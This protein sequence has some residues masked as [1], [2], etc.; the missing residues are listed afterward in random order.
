MI[1]IFQLILTGAVLF[2]LW[3]VQRD[4]AAIADESRQKD[5]LA[6]Q[7]ERFGA[8]FADVAEKKKAGKKVVTF[9]ARDD[10]A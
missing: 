10:E 1:A 5:E 8:M 9:E 2:F 7:V 3:K 6:K 4:T